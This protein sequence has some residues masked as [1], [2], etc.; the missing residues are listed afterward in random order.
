MSLSEA[1]TIRYSK[2]EVSLR[3]ST[4]LKHIF[5]LNK[6][7]PRAMVVSHSKQLKAFCDLS[8]YKV[9]KSKN[10]K[11]SVYRYPLEALS[12]Y[13][14]ITVKAIRDSIGVPASE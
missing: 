13:Y 3:V 5:F 14:G 11:Y 2:P 9:D 6:T 8:G 12:A 4:F 7:V 1:S 10:G